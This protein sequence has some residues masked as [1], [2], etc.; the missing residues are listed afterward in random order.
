MW[1]NQNQVKS[2]DRIGGD[3]RL[4][5]CEGVAAGA[6]VVST[7]VGTE[8]PDVSGGRDIA[9]AD[10]PSSIARPCGYL[11]YNCDFA[12]VRAA[13]AL[14]LITERLSGNQFAGHFERILTQTACVG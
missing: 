7:R 9:L 14:L 2:K 8:S 11:L 6:P 10:E 3:P 4:K 1:N 5:T 13:S 12:D